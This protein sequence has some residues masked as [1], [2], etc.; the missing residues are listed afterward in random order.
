LTQIDIQPSEKTKKPEWFRAQFPSG[1]K[2][3]EI[4]DLLRNETLH[5]V[6]EEAR[7]PNIGEC[8]NSGTATFMIL[9]DTCTRACGFCAV[10]SGK[11]GELDILEPIRLANTVAR[12]NLDYCVITSVNRDDVKDGGASIFAGCINGIHKLLP[13]CNVEVL[14]PDFE[15]N[16]DALEKVLLAGPAVLNHNTE[17]IKEYYRFVRP[18]GKY[19]RTLE[20]F[21]KSK[22]IAPN[23][24]TKTGI[25][26]GL[27]ETMDELK[28][29]I[30][31][32]RQQDANLL[33]IGQYLQ[34]TKKHL[35]IKKFWHPDEF[36]EIKDFALE[37]GFEHVE[38]GPL[39]RSSYH[40][41]EQYAAFRNS[42][43]KTN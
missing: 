5:T 4:K 1:K 40:A 32:V 38:S 37:V 3:T 16:W 36:L 19:E 25:M 11:P 18:K 21:R 23:I 20:L 22:E 43:S 12:L 17:T 41:A 10:N 35:P 8:F 24:P 28:S 29:T 7:C 42:M 27:G 2:F 9:G 31:D 14:I 34:P 15:G 6:C 39:V 13:N 30:E 33:T 26:V